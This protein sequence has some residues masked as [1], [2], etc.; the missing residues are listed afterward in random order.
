VK[1]VELVDDKISGTLP[2]NN[3]VKLFLEVLDNDWPSTTLNITAVEAVGSPRGTAEVD[4]VKNYVVYRVST[5]G[6]EVGTNY[7]DR[8]R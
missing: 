4:Y 5:T 8:F 1:A 7:I 3:A 6:M 2:P